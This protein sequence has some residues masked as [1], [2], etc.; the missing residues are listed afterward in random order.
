MRERYFVYLCFGTNEQMEELNN[1]L[2]MNGYDFSMNGMELIV[3]ADEGDYVETIMADRNIDYILDDV[4][5]R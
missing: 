3:H 2:D 4:E 1:H 5:W